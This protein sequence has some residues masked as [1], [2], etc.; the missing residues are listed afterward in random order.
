MKA[1]TPVKGKP[2]DFCRLYV[3]IFE[4]K[5]GNNRQYYKDH[6]VKTQES[7]LKDYRG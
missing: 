7:F 4:C 5:K 2:T 1:A 6:T 3:T